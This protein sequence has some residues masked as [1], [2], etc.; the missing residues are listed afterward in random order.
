MIKKIFNTIFNKKEENPESRKYILKYGSIFLAIVSAIMTFFNIRMKYTAMTV[1]TTVLVIGFIIAFICVIKNRSQIAEWI[2]FFLCGALFTLFALTGENNGFAILW[3]L[4]V[5]VLG[6]QFIGLRKGFYLSVYFQLLLIV[7]FYTPL[8]VSMENFYTDTFMMRFP[9]LYFASF[10]AST[11]L[12]W[13]REDLLAKL[14]RQ[15][16]IDGLTELYNRAYFNMFS[17]EAVLTNCSILA[18]D[19]NQLKKVNDTLGHEAGDKLIKDAADEIRKAFKDDTCFRLGG[20]EF[21][22]VSYKDV[23]CGIK[24]LRNSDV[25][26]AIGFVN[27]SNYPDLSFS[28]LVK[29]ADKLMYK[30]KSDYYNRLGI[31]RRKRN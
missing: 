24:K 7:L 1:A 11:I 2:I 21:L 12:V 27:S 17:K 18:I 22:I 4:L 15:A 6:M 23:S 5:P 10:G 13:E 14:N 3:I 16:Y 31:D 29:E 25:S 19:L 9:A 30:D 28:D 20:D 26:M 8:R